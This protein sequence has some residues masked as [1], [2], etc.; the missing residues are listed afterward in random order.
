MIV[1]RTRVAMII[2]TR[3][4]AEAWDPTPPPP[5]GTASRHVW[6]HVNTYSRVATYLTS[7]TVGAELA[8]QPVPPTY[9]LFLFPSARE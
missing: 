7:L 3:R 2:L 1:L 5:G 4:T 6:H 8:A 9:C